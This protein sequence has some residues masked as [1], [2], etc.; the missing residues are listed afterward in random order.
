MLWFAGAVGLFVCLI[1]SRHYLGRVLL[2]VCLPAFAGVSL[3]T[4]NLLLGETHP[5]PLLSALLLALAKRPAWLCSVAWG[6]GPGIHCAVCGLLFVALYILSV[7]FTSADASARSASPLATDDISHKE[8]RRARLFI[9]LSVVIFV[10]T[11][12]LSN[13]LV[14]S[15]ELNSLLFLAAF[16]RTL[17]LVIPGLLLIWLIGSTWK[18][19]WRDVLRL[20]SLTYLT[21][22]ALIPIGVS[23]FFVLCNYVNRRFVYLDST[24]SDRP[25]E[26]H[27][28]PVAALFL[29]LPS[30]LE[31]NAYRGFLLPHFGKRFGLTRGAFFVGIAWA[32][33]HLYV[34]LSS[35]TSDWSVILYF[36]SRIT[37]LV[38]LN[39]VL[40]WLTLKSG[41]IFPATI[42]H[43]IDNAMILNASNGGLAWSVPLRALVW[44]V[45]ATF[46]FR[47]WPPVLTTSEGFPNPV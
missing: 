38:A 41:S 1:S 8:W 27:F 14:N 43:G 19:Y 47:Y 10:P 26:L 13:L 39:F 46:L 6:I 4:G 44:L 31:E 37:G 32:A 36:V 18:Q 30:F 5:T 9:W 34:D 12:L 17:D 40:S 7:A 20:P 33:T 11:Q 15:L 22:C 28:P 21:I 35:D 45:I 23:L 25:H 24:L 16:S 2:L 3:I 29:F 42:A